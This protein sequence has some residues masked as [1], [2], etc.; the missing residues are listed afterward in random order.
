MDF[1]PAH[2][3]WADAA[4]RVT[5]PTLRARI[6]G[7]WGLALSAPQVWALVRGRGFRRVVPRQRHYQA[8]PAALAVAEKN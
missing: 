7:S 5:M 3:A 8:D 6:R 4:P 1:E 2:L